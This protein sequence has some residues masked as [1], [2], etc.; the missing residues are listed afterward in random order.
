MT[1]IIIS[2]CSGHMGHVLT[3]LIEADPE[4][5]AVAGI[6]PVADASCGYPVFA[7]AAECTV[8]AD[9][10]IDFSN[11]RAVDALLDYAVEKKLPLVLCTTGLSEDQLQKVEEA[12]RQTAILRSANMSLGINLLMKLLKEAAA[13]LA[14][15][16]YDMEIVEKHHNRKLDAPSG[17]AIALGE[18]MN[19]ALDNQY[20]FVFDRSQRHEKRDPKEIGI[21]SVRG[22]SIVGEH[23]VIFAGQDEVITFSH[24][25]YSR[26]IFGKGAVEAAKFL[27]GKPA[28]KY[29]MSDLF[30][31]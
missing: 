6:D 13:R 5:T 8:P 18:S 12:S 2:G 7:S 16:G 31:V 1:K 17:T 30:S 20:H 10:I 26:S 15:A 21:S 27:A 19:E 11:F 24:S 3:Q 9:V 22:G 25:A 29:D 14:P 23:E 4:T 28:G